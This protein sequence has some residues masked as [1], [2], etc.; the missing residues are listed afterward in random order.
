MLLCLFCNSTLL[1]HNRVDH[2]LASR[3]TSTL[4]RNVKTLTSDLCASDSD[5][6]SEAETSAA[7]QTKH[8]N[9]TCNN[10]FTQLAREQR[11]QVLTTTS[12][13]T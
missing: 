6:G 1:S 8:Y 13:T 12:G 7:C 4:V 2:L 11:E 10:K 9:A 5:T 3:L